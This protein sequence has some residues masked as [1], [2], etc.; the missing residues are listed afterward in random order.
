MSEL[1]KAAR[2]LVERIDREGC[3]PLDWPEY[4]ALTAALEQ[5]AQ[6][7]PVGH[8]SVNDYGRW[9]ENEGEY[10]QP[11]YDRPQA[12]DWVELTDEELYELW[13]E[14]VPSPNIF[15]RAIEAKL[16]EKNT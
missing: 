9:E 11:L 16:R 6:Q 15:A 3:T 7:E 10:G 12:H 2:L 8:F 1:E 4:D 14:S 5:P 13:N